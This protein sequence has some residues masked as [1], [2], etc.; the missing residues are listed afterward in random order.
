MVQEINIYFPRKLV[1]GKAS[2]ENLPAEIFALSCKKVFIL[3]IEPLLPIIN[4]L[5]SALKK[6]GVKVQIHTGIVQE[7][8]FK[9]V[10]ELMQEAANFNPDLVAGIGGGSVLDVAKLVAALLDNEQ[11]LRDITG[12]GLLKQRRKHLICLPA[13]SG[14]GSEASPN[15]IL[16]DETDNQKKGII[17]PF[18]VPDIVYI[19][20]LL[21]LSVP[22]SITA[23][24]G[25]DALTHCIE[26]YTNK[27]AHPFIDMYALEGIRLIAANI[28][29]AV[30]NGNDEEARTEVALGSLF[31]GICL[32]PV[33]TA[34]VHALAY[35]LG[36]MFHLAHGLSNALLLPYVMEFNLPTS[37]C[38]Y[39]KVAIALGCEPGENDMATAQKG[40]AKIRSL[41][42][43]CGLPSGLSDAGITKDA[44][45][46]MAKDAMKITRLLKNNPRPVT[47]QDAVTIFNAAF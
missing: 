12:I 23:A 43:D 15:S 5:A 35:P 38:R 24:T 20:P 27:F 29:R 2:I 41:L 13:T 8:F 3:T 11:T 47:E 19:D 33:N 34:A 44:I 40:I 42:N 22:A 14:T 16:V 31:G 39:A 7:P 37:P 28:V 18:L 21:T 45:P 17:S 6:E 36:S 25:I 10:E 46:A 32:G 26:A 4:K 9:D 30:K 1:I